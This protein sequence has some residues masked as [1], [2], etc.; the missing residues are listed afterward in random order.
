MRKRYLRATLV[1]DLKDEVEKADKA[2]RSRQ[3]ER[4]INHENETLLY[5]QI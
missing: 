3:A 2:D 5:D 4:A 1:E